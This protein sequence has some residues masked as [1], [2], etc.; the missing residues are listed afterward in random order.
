VSA[1][2]FSSKFILVAVGSS[3]A[4]GRWGAWLGL[5]AQNLFV[6]DMVLLLS[7][8]AIFPRYLI[9]N[10]FMLFLFVIYC[11][12][13]FSRN[14]STSIALRLRD[15]MPFIYLILFLI[16]KNQINLIPKKDI[17]AMLKVSTFIGLIWNFLISIKAINTFSFDTFVGIPIFSQRPDHFGIMAAI[18]IIVWSNSIFNSDKRNIFNSIVVCLFI[19]EVFLLPSRAGFLAMMVGL[20]FIVVKY[21]RKQIIKVIFLMSTLLIASVSLSSALYN[22]L[23]DVS[24]VKK[25]ISFGKNADILEQGAG[26][27]RGR[28]NGQGAL[29]DWVSS[30]NLQWVG[31]GPGREILNESGAI[32]WLSGDLDVRYPHN[33]WTS[34]FARFGIFGFL[35]WVLA[36]IFLWR[37]NF[38][39]NL[40]FSSTIIVAILIASTFGVIIESPFGIIPLYFFLMKRNL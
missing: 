35:L 32:R 17:Y 3:L 30:N 34:L 16:L 13:Q 36:F 26:T 4:F 21:H 8:V 24:L 5:P 25:T 10:K 18:G 11:L 12:Y 20:I 14:P 33:W 6:I 22:L 2:D 31:G 38:Q 39:K 23:P 15:L 28:L 37:E 27:A 19:V 1:I 29:I 40:N 9:K 7:A